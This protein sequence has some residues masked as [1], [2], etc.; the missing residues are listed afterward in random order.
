M[1]CMCSCRIV[2]TIPVVSKKGLSIGWMDLSF[3]FFHRLVVVLIHNNWRPVINGLEE[4]RRFFQIIF[5]CKMSPRRGRSMSFNIF[6]GDL[7]L[8]RIWFN[9]RWW[10]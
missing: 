6:S 2:S 5:F 7:R 10:L 4:F 8:L 1:K 9:G 3:C